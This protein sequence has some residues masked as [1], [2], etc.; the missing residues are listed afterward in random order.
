MTCMEFEAYNDMNGIEAYD[1]NHGR[2]PP[3]LDINF[4]ARMFDSDIVA[5][6]LVINMDAHT[7]CTPGRKSPWLDINIDAHM[8]NID[9][10]CA[11]VMQITKK[12]AMARHQH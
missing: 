9:H 5:R 4:D 2:K 6:M 12:P 10:C 1:A 7:C 11:H 8:L 3:W